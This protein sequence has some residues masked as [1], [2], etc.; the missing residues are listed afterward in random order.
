MTFN[1]LCNIYKAVHVDG[2]RLNVVKRAVKLLNLSSIRVTVWFVGHDEYWW[3][4]SYVWWIWRGWRSG[5]EY[6]RTEQKVEKA[7]P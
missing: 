3:T 5:M 4:G 2:V 7:K 6:K 1:R